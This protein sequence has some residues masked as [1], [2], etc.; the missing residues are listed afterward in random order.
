[1]KCAELVM[2]RREC[3]KKFK[4]QY[5]QDKKFRGKCKYD[6]SIVMNHLIS[7]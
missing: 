2:F 4:S 7:I 3:R 1:M 5:C 6:L